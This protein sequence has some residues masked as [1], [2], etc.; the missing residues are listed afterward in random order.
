MLKTRAKLIQRN[1]IKLKEDIQDT[2]THGIRKKGARRI[3][4]CRIFNE[5]S[6]RKLPEQLG[7]EDLKRST[8]DLKPLDL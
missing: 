8:L 7:R 1:V 3:Y 6:Y 4:V 2:H 5:I